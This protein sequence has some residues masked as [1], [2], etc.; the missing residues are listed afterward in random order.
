MSVSARSNTLVNSYNSN[1]AVARTR[2][3]E[4]PRPAPAPP[5]PPAPATPAPQRTAAT[6]LTVRSSRLVAAHQ[7][8]ARGLENQLRSGTPFRGTPALGT[9]GSA[10]DPLAALSRG[11]PGASARVPP[12]LSAALLETP[13]TA[14]EH[15]EEGATVDFLRG[16][17]ALDTS[18]SGPVGS[19]VTNDLNRGRLV[20]FRTDSTRENGQVTS[21]S[22]AT[23]DTR[24]TGSGTT[25]TT[26]RSTSEADGRDIHTRTTTSNQ[27]TAEGSTSRTDHSVRGTGSNG[28]AVESH[29]ATTSTTRNGQTETTRTRTTHGTSGVNTTRRTSTAEAPAQ[30][31]R[32]QQL[33][34]GM[35][36]NRTANLNVATYHRELLRTQAYSGHLGQAAPL[37]REQTGAR[38]EVNVLQAT[39]DARGQAQVDLR[40]GRVNVSARLE[41]RADVVNVSARAQA[42]NANSVRGQVFAQAEGHVGARAEV[43]ADVQFDPRNGNV[44]LGG[45]FSGFAGAEVTASTGYE[46]RYVSVDAEV[47]GQAGAGATARAELSFNDGQLRANLDVSAALGLGGGFKINVNVNFRAIGEDLAQGAQDLWNGGRRVVGDMLHGAASFLGLTSPEPSGAAAIGGAFSNM[48]AMAARSAQTAFAGMSG[49]VAGARLMGNVLTAQS[50]VRAGASGIARAAQNLAA[51]ARRTEQHNRQAARHI[52]RQSIQS[53]FQAAN[54]MMRALLRH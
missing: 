34:H 3:P 53:G 8:G 52:A 10:N 39:A 16:K 45:G 4:A 24:M 18:E 15:A 27:R 26:N 20:G 30:R 7:Q 28:R 46:N 54:F 35:V 36:E 48:G 32:T 31:T 51:Q 12:D 1:P 29:Q 19:R 13:G 44:R 6:A 40:T 33:R 37:R 42:G 41:G 2:P 21:R 25:T 9:G 11:I 22:T 49:A 23:T 17:G 14:G 38:A 43:G 50:A 47:R 5:P